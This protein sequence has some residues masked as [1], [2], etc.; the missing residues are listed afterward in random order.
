[1]ETTP[2]YAVGKRSIGKLMH[3]LDPANIVR[4]YR[5][6][7]ESWQ[8][9]GAEWYPRYVTLVSDYARSNGVG[10][11]GAIGAFS[12][13]SSGASPDT[14]FALLGSMIAHLRHGASLDYL[15]AKPADT[16]KA[17]SCLL[18]DSY[19]FV[20]GQKV[21]SYLASL[22]GE[23]DDPCMDRHAVAIA[24]GM[25]NQGDYKVTAKMYRDCQTA[26]R[27]AARELGIAPR[28]LQEWTWTWRKAILDDSSSIVT[29]PADLGDL[30][31]LRPY[32]WTSKKDEA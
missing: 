26:Y 16:G 19:G 14:N 5:S 23:E 15:P 29:N 1:M 18:C 13:L 4:L 12:I 2:V 32:G 11:D 31:D 28:T 21:E 7:P 17:L 3:R 20:S 6:M 22:L 30:V 8:G 10:F 27:I 24:L 25:Q 9:R